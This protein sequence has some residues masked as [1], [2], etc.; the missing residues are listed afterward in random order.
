MTSIVFLN[1]SLLNHYDNNGSLLI[2][3]ILTLIL[4]FVF[5]LPSTLTIYFQDQLKINAEVENTSKFSFR[6][7][8]D[9]KINFILILNKF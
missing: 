3:L 7:N 9:F 4:I 2:K 5:I 1:I 6:S 8:S